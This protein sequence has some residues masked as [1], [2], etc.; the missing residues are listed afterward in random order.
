[1]VVAGTTG[2][3]AALTDRERWELLAAVL[4]A[5][6]PR[7]A[8]VVAGTGAVT[9]ERAARLTAE[10]ADHGADAALVLSPPW[11]PDPRP[12]YE[13]VAKAAP[14]LPLLAYHYPAASA[15]GIPVELLRDLP[16]TG[17]K[18]STGDCDRLLETLTAWGGHLY[19]GSSAVVSYA[20]QL[21][22]PG[23][24]LALANAE[25]E[26]CVAAFDGDGAAQRELAA[27]HTAMRTGGFPA[28]IKAQTAARWG[29]SIRAR[30]GG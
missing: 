21:G 14:D 30:I 26:R 2:G 13:Q 15:P 16:V 24:I 25:P 12:Y 5:V 8:T 1:V 20:G 9:G 17:C 19:V 4:G 18:D 11:T 22:L 29:T 28:G 7:R 27:A 10:A 23:A 6:R 3:A